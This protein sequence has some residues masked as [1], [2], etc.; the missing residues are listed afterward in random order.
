MLSMLRSS[1]A[2]RSGRVGFGSLDRGKGRTE[3]TIERPEDVDERL[4]EF[5]GQ[6]CQ[7]CC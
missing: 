6:R 4:V 7:V 2:G 1:L 5:Q 3:R